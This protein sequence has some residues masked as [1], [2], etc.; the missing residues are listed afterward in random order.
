MRCPYCGETDNKVIDSRIVRQGSAIWRRRQCLNCELRFTTYETVEQLPVMVVKKDGSRE[1]YSR[2]K[3]L[4]G[5]LRACVKR[6]V[7]RTQMEQLAD[8]LEASFE[9]GKAKEISSRDIG[10]FLLNH[11]FL[12]D[13]VAYVRFASVYREFN[14]IHHFMDELRKLV[15]K[16]RPKPPCT[17]S[18]IQP[19]K[20]S[21][22]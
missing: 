12:I 6:P 16:R 5:L 22:P 20:E 18:K 4:H 14:D 10:E 19:E 13:Q 15:H 1:E 17:N 3:I 2:D 11:L 8:R 21:D 7:T 9:A